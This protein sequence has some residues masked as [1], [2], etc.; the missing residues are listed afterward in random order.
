[1][2]QESFKLKLKEGKIVI[3]P[4]CSTDSPSVINIIAL[5]GMD[6]CI[7]DMEHG[8]TNIQN[9]EELIR[10]AKSE[11][12]AA[13][14]RVDSLNEI[15]ILKSLDSGASG[16]IVPHVSNAETM[17][18]VV[19]YTKYYPIGKRGF[20]SFTCAGKYSL[21][22]VQKHA[23]LQNS[24]IVVGIIIEDLE[25]VN[26]LKE[27]LEVGNLDLVY[28]GAYDLAQSMGYPGNPTHPEVLEVLKNCVAT[29]NKYDIAVGGYAAKSINE[30]ENMIKL[31]MQFITYI[32]DVTVIYHA[33]KSIKDSFDHTVQSTAGSLS[34]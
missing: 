34:N 18:K 30:L 21:E 26:N 29:V 5:S 23:E 10:A 4:W 31:G 19:D 15:S 16:V 3:G 25:G 11:D 20:S 13:L 33:F 2:K 1:M 32:P 7:L 24:S 22:N 27:I 9:M 8:K 17:K 14:V 12:C 28:I 6:F